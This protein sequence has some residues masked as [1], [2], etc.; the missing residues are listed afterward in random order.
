VLKIF[1]E[2]MLENRDHALFQEFF[3]Q[4]GH[5]MKNLKQLVKTQAS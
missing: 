2:V 3:Q 4:F 5:F 1:S